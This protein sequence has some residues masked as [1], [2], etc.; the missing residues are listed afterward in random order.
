MAETACQSK[1]S[2]T[3]DQDNTQMETEDFFAD[4]VDVGS[5]N[6]QEQISKDTQTELSGEKPEP[7][8]NKSTIACTIAHLICSNAS[9][10]SRKGIKQVY[11]IRK[12]ET[13]TTL[14]VGL[15]LHSDTRRM[16][17]VKEFHQIGLCL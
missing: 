12:R 5:E 10:R 15:T 9:K 3:E 2:D 14:Y 17:D 11:H 1:S 6:Q 8:R 4:S 13:P 7:T 16:K